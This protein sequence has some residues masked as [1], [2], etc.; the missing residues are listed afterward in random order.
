LFS[1]FSES[2]GDSIWLE[3]ALERAAISLNLRSAPGSYFGANAAFR[4]DTR[5]GALRS[6]Y[7]PAENRILARAGASSGFTHRTAR[8]MRI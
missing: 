8:L 1:A 7:N 3:D 6:D 4:P 5:L 2:S